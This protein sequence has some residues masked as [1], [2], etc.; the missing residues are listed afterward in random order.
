M[1]VSIQDNDALSAVSPAALSAYARAGGWTKGQPYGDHSDVYAREGTP[2]I[3]IPKHRRLGDYA[4]VVSR[5]IEIFAKAAETDALSL[6]RDLIVADRD[7]VRIRAA[8]DGAEGSVALDDGVSLI[9]GA[10]DMIAAAAC[11]LREPRRFYRAGANRE[12]ADYL[13]RV[14]LGQTEQGSFVVTL[15]GPVVPPPVRAK[16]LFDSTPDDE[17]VERRMMQR[18]A[19]ALT[20]TREAAERASGGDD[21]AFPEAVERGASANLCEALATL[22]EPFHG[23]DVG[24]S[25]ARI[26]PMNAARET[27]RFGAS[28]API[29][30]E[31]ARWFREEE[32]RPDV[33]LIGRIRR[34]Q[35]DDREADGTITLRTYIDGRVQSV[36]AA[37]NRPDYDRAIQAH[38][39]GTLVAMMG[40]LERFGQ[41]W[42]LRNSR[43]AAVIPDEEDEDV[44]LRGRDS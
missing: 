43:I 42:R 38:K 19:E 41:R 16:A 8:P 27:I 4:S 32:P 20:A 18:L 23:I 39:S 9:T 12:A 17:P 26:R 33:S 24:L 3:V 36:T 22:I 2:E 34:L 29:L 13:R 40:D 6:Y 31:A 35:R 21:D 15:V 25:W 44:D 10:R 11:S 28:D 1:K 30:R 5:L 14:Q 37:L 7:V